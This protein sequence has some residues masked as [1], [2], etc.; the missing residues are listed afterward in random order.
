[1]S[2]V[3]RTM[4]GFTLIELMIVVAIIGILASIAVPQ[5]RD[6]VVRSRWQYNFQLLGSVKQAIAECAQVNGFNAVAP[7]CNAWVIGST[8]TADLVGAGFLP[9]SFNPAGPY[10]GSM[11]MVSGVVTITGNSLARDC[12][13]TVEPRINPGR[14]SV[15]W[16]FA[17]VGG[18]CRRAQ[19]GVGT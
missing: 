13:V 9:S 14:N 17:N 10:L 2:S 6:Y 5:Y 12:V 15:E 1:M 16:G 3:D 11:A 4:L 7:P 19:T 18:H 8:G